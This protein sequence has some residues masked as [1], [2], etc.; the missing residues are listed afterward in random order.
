MIKTL[1]FF[2]FTGLWWP[3]RTS[4]RN[5]NMY[6]VRKWRKNINMTFHDLQWVTWKSSLITP[7][8]AS[9]FPVWHSQFFCTSS[10]V[11]HEVMDV[12]A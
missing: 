2:H 6:F 11:F 5:G 3:L 7:N 4:L 8:F 10:H 9:Y 12:E 1:G